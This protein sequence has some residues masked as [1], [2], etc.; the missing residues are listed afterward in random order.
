M[1]KEIEAQQGSQEWHNARAGVI[2]GSKFGCIITPTGKKSTQVEKYI[3]ELLGDC[4]AG[5]KASGNFRGNSYTENG[6]ELE[7]EAVAMYEALTGATTKEVGFCLSDKGY[8]GASPDRLVSDDGL[9]EIKCPA[10]FTHAEYLYNNK[11]EMKYFPQM[12]GQMLVTGR[13]WCD[14]M[15]YHPDMP[16]LVIRVERDEGYLI[17]MASYLSDAIELLETKKQKLKDMGYL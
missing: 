5:Q 1:Y 16:P 7:P 10:P 9:L 8:Y 2:T 13:K 12:Q 4:I 15:S 3:F 17:K 6:N 14:W 11:L